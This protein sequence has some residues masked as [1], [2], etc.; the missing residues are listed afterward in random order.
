MQDRNS[1]WTGQWHTLR[2]EFQGNRFTVTFDG[3]Q[4]LEATDETSA[5]AGKVGVWTKADSVTLFDDFTWG[6]NKHLRRRRLCACQGTGE[7]HYATIE[8]IFGHRSLFPSLAFVG[9]NCCP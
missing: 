2:V 7:E 8:R 3:Q 5:A 1:A 6:A 4:V 9:M